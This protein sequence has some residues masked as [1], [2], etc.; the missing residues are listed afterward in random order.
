[1]NIQDWF[2]LGLTSLISLQ[3]LSRV[4]SN[5]TVQKH[6]FFHAQPSLWS[7]ALTRWAFGGK[8]MSLIFNMLS[9][10][11]TVFLP[12][13]KHLLIPWLQSPSTVV[14]EPPEIKPLT[15]YHKKTVEYPSRDGNT[16][17]LYLPSEKSVSRSRSNRY[18]RT[19]N[20]TGSKLEKEY[21]KVV[22][23]HPAY[24]TYMQDTSCKTQPW[25]DLRGG[26]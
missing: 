14:L 12:R 16:R 21:I 22:Y 6:Q 1:M 5:I 23:W 24:L 3:G 13:S 11:V 15:V 17:P 8:V 25:M 4:F 19:C 7:I 20:R 10:L 9:R 26:P 18:N 2:P